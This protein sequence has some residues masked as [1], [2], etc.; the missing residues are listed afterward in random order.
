[1]KSHARIDRRVMF[2]EKWIAKYLW[3]IAVAMSFAL[4]TPGRLAAQSN[5]LQAFHSKVLHAFTGQQDGATLYGGVIV[6][7]DGN[8]YGTAVQGGDL[9]CPD[10]RGYGCGAVFKI[11]PTGQL[12][13]V[14][15]FHGG[16]DGAL[17]DVYSAAGVVR[18]DAGNL[19]GITAYGGDPS[20]W[21]GV[22]Y[23]IDRQGNYSVI[24]MFNGADGLNPG[25]TLLFSSDGNLYGTAF[26]GGGDQCG[27]FGCGVVFKMDT[28]GNE[29]IL[30][31]FRETGGDGTFPGA[32]GPLAQ[33]RDGNLYGTTGLGGAFGQGV[34]YK[35][36]LHGNEN[37]LYP[38]TG[39]NDGSGPS[40]SVVVDDVGNAYGTTAQGGT[41]NSGVVFKVDPMG[42]ETVLYNFTGGT[43]GGKQV[44]SSLVR[45][46]Q[47]NLYGTTYGGGDLTTDLCADFGCGVVF[48]IYPSGHET[49]L[50]AFKGTDGAIPYTGVFRDRIGNLYG[51]TGAGG[52]L[53]C[54]GGFGCGVVFKLSAC[55]S[56]LCRGQ[57]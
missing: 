17:L 19:Y 5:A 57:D 23:K 13:T 11:D 28:Q 39:G 6:D 44:Y 3:T 8:V 56:A 51:A 42:H 46:N 24:H 9:A 48:K 14:H 29:T 27:G 36:D 10:G 43:D 54:G 15:A 55:N 25:Q 2:P 7:A 45:D 20:C 49:V 37:V 34:V 32:F 12:T 53:G 50:Y 52:D 4:A 47:G 21:C 40:G 1:M 26:Q 16:T 22:V 38:F 31:R 33:D 30:Y 18:D 41:H 35:V